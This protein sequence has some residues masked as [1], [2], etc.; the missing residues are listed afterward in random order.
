MQSTTRATV[1]SGA[2]K[3][4]TNYRSHL[5][6]LCARRGPWREF[7]TEEQQILSSKVQN[8][9]TK[10]TD[11]PDLRTIAQTHR[12]YAGQNILLQG[13]RTYSTRG[14]NRTRHSLLSQVFSCFRLS[15]PR[16]TSLHCAEHVCVYMYTHLCLT[17]YELPLVPNNTE[18]KHSYTNRSGAKCWL[19]IYR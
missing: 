13:C 7:H 12:R 18:V 10:T 15:D 5:K 6:V 3:F 16:P 2:H 4:S 1:T 17:V 19:G 8:L 9:A 11:A 14:Q